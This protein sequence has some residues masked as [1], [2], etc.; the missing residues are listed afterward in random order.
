MA[1]LE[2][3]LAERALRRSLAAGARKTAMLDR[4]I[5]LL[6]RTRELYRSQYFDMG[7]RQL[8]ELLDNEEE[9]YARQAELAELRATLA[10]DRLDC[11]V[12]SRVLRRELGLEGHSLHGFPLAPES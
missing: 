1:R 4:Q 10:A 5:E 6:S 8:S 7:T 12:R 3:T 11:A 2:E 9:Y